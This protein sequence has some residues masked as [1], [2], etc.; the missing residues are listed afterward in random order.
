MDFI[1]TLLGGTFYMPAPSALGWLV[2]LLLFGLTV[3]ALYRWRGLQ[4]SIK[5]RAWGYLFVLLLFTPIA[6]LFLGVRLP[7][8][9]ALP[10]P[11]VPA[12]PLPPALMLFS[13]LPWMLAAGPLGPIGAAIIGGLSGLLRGVWDTH[14]VF[15]IL[16]LAFLA[17]LFAANMRQRYRT[18]TYGLLRQPLVSAL[19]LIPLHIVIYLLGIFLTVPGQTAVRLDYALSNAGVAA[20]SFS[21]EVLFAG[22]VMQVLAAFFPSAWGRGASLQPSPSEQSLE[23]RFLFGTGTFISLL[24]LTL[25]I[26]DWVV[27]GQAAREMLRDRLASAAD[28]AAQSVPFFLE[29]GQNLAVQ[30]ATD[31]RLLEA[32]EPEL[33]SILGQRMQSSPYFDQFIILDV[34]TQAVLGGYPSASRETFGLFPEEEAGLSLAAEGGVLIQIYTVPPLKPGE[35]AAR[36][37]FMV[38]IVDGDGQV[39]R[40]LIGRTDL[41]TNPLTQPLISSLQGMTG[42]GGEGMLIDD[43]NVILYH[44]NPG[45]VNTDYDGPQDPANPFSTHT[46]PDGTRQYVYYQPVEGRAWAVALTI[47]AWQAQELALL[48]AMP[49]SIMILLLAVVALLSLRFGLRTVTGSLHTLAVEADRIAKGNLDHPLKLEGVDEVGQ[50]RRAFEQM[51]ASLQARL[52]ELNRLLVVSQGVASSLE[53]RD[54]VKPVL[55][56]VLDTGASAVRVVLSPAIL[57]KTSIELPSRFG[58]GPAGDKYA[59]FDEQILQHVQAQDRLVLSNLTRPR[60][61]DLDPNLPQPASLLAVAMR[62][63]NRYYG[64]MWAAYDQPRAFSESDA[65]FVTTLA[66]QAALATSNAH[67][68]L[69]VE[70]SRRQLEAILNSTPDPVLVIDPQN[71][72]LLANPAAAKVVGVDIAQSSGQNIEELIEQKTLLDLLRAAPSEKQSAEIVFNGGRTFLATASSVVA[73]GRPVGRVCILRDVTHF[74][75][76]DSMKSE[77]VAT[78]SHDLRSPLTLMRGYATMLE[79]VGELND[80]QQGYVRKIVSGVENMSRLVNNL[81]D[82]GRIEIGVGLQVE[83][84]PIHDIVERVVGALQLQAS[85]K[86]IQLSVDAMRDVPA[87][88]EADQALLHQG[89]YNLVENA[90]KYT[91][92]GGLVNLRVRATQKELVFEVQD[93]GIGISPSDLPRLFEK[94]YRGKQRDARSQHGS[95]LGL[96]IVRSIAERHG[97]KVWV[98]SELGEGSTFFLQV[99]LAQSFGVPSL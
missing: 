60:T 40:V 21:G 72:L 76:L 15:S 62:H 50:L 49:L 8:E 99:P 63:E 42:S 44:P 4:P 67:L 29:T 55:E 36:V 66:G 81:L 53:M 51:R 88:V 7:S 43:L 39:Q 71:R 23:N 25:L 30:L 61:L 94:F 98:E 9:S 12:E 27:A 69:S 19:L 70:A 86:N 18:F 74:K 84:V 80:Q 3:Y 45:L 1:G 35:G 95:G 79:M 32:T 38:G 2:W 83:T 89:V 11:G 41:G 56:A 10:P 5:G 54:A 26:G 91:P 97:G 47:P 28:T 52:D 77:F 48:T 20:L 68:F 6:S 24:L 73:E 34:S 85:Q 93:N 37:S 46:A 33:S 14:T 64:A 65:R 96:A 90:I 92:N 87:T 13:A 57:P 22:L 75:E 17:A 82:L 59:H 31:P 78:V 16:D 58:L